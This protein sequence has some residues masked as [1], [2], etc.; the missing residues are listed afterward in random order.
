MKLRSR[1][2]V[3]YA[4]ALHD[5]AAAAQC[6]E[7]V[8]R[9]MRRLRQWIAGVAGLSGFL[10]NALLPRQHRQTILSRLFEGAVE[11][12]T[13]RF[14]CLVES[15]RR[16][17]LLDDI[18]ASFLEHDEARQGIVRGRLTAVATPGPAEVGEITA[19]AGRRTGKRVVLQTAEDPA[20]LGGYRLQ[21]GDT[22]YDL[23][24]AARL[25]MLRRT[26]AAV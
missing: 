25:R 6:G 17:G 5:L 11:P 10:A 8:A 15:K 3:R 13:W 21:V 7:A 9:D 23:S 26:M 18:C 16:M 1:A 19:R 12:L 4:V 2:A 14:L 24:L 22:V 20:L